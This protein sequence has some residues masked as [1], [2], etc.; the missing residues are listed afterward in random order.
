LSRV[1]EKSSVIR[2]QQNYYKRPRP[3][4]KKVKQEMKLNN[5]MRFLEIYRR[6]KGSEGENGDLKKTNMYQSK[7]PFTAMLQRKDRNIRFPGALYGERKRG[8]RKRN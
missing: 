3:Q 4:V 1:G 8:L 2:E 6:R 7:G 5:R